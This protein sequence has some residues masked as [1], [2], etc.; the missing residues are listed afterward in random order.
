MDRGEREILKAGVRR[1]RT[2]RDLSFPARPNPLKEGN[3]KGNL[4]KTFQKTSAWIPETGQ[5]G[6]PAENVGM[7]Y[8]LREEK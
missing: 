2:V 4:R 6:T 5:R 7:E 1:G 8:R 3:K